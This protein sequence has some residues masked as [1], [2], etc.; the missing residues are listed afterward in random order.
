MSAKQVVKSTQVFLCFSV[1]MH[2]TCIVLIYL[3]WSGFFSK[4]TDGMENP[5]KME[6]YLW[7]HQVKKTFCGLIQQHRVYRDENLEIYCAAKVKFFEHQVKWLV[8]LIS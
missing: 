4:A 1:K 2:G 8:V 3:A 6:D 7:E 5:V